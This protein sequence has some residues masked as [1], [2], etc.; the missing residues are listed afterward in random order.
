VPGEPELKSKID[1]IDGDIAARNKERLAMLNSLAALTDFK[2]L[3]FEKG[4][5]LEDIVIDAMRLLGFKAERYGEGDME[6]DLILECEE[7]RI[8]GEI[9]GKDKEPIKIEKL[10][11]L[12]RVVDEDFH[13]N[14]IL[15]DGLLIGNPYR[16]QL[17]EERKAAFSNKVIVAAGR[18]RF[19]LLSTVELY[20]AVIEVLKNPSEELKRALRER[21]FHGLGGII[22][23]ENK[24]NVL[25][26]TIGDRKAGK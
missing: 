7:G 22:S 25:G 4:K 15:A 9:E 5:I 26:S 23:F 14:E 20:R 19:G 3:L 2:G 16:L 24:L 11:Q 10:D 6:H 18:K 8:I 21:I 1:A 13:R 17:V 12:S